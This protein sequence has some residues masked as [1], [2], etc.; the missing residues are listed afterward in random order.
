MRRI[1]NHAALAACVLC[2][3]RIAS[4][5]SITWHLARL[6]IRIYDEVELMV[7]KLDAQSS[8]VAVTSPRNAFIVCWEVNPNISGIRDVRADAL[9]KDHS[10]AQGSMLQLQDLPWLLWSRSADEQAQES[11]SLRMLPGFFAW[12]S[13]LSRSSC[14]RGKANILTQCWSRTAYP[15][16]SWSTTSVF[17]WWGT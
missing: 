2:R 11:C 5:A 14:L 10:V 7:E 13:I 6:G 1:A 17:E 12:V 9:S 16:Q 15:T 4:M 8:W 3:P